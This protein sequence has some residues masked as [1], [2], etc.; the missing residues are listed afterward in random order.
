MLL[1]LSFC[2]SVNMRQ[3]SLL[4]N[5]NSS[6][7]I[8]VVGGGQLAQMLCEAAERRNIDVAIQTASN[9]DPAVKTANKLIL[10]EP[11]NIKGTRELAEGCTCVTFENEWVN[12]EEL[13]ILEKE[14]VHFLPH[15]DSLTPL[16]DKI[17]QR[18][19]LGE[20]N[21]PSTDWILLSSNE[22]SESK[23]PLDWSFPLM[24]K[25]SKGGY[26][27][28]GTKV[29]RNSND[30]CELLKTVNR[31]NWFLEK[32]VE[33]EKEYSLV[34]TRDLQGHIRAY[35]LAETNQLNQV[36][37]WVIVPA[38]ASHPVKNMA[39]NIAASLLT[40]LNYFGV[41]AI[42]FFYGNSGL[43]VNEIAPRT[44]NS[45]HFSIEA[46]KSSQFD[47]QICIAA[48]LPL[49]STDLVTPGALM[50]N[51]LGLS[52]E[53]SVSLDDR[54]NAI[55]AVKGAKLH[56][57]GKD[58]EKPGRKLGHVTFLLSGKDVISRRDEALSLLKKIRTIWPMNS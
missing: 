38:G 13:K 15:I 10:S 24:A 3:A 57:Y 52:S 16:V 37:D 50:I 58:E 30:L 22:I 48:G 56:W 20:L 11:Q 25:A 41:I 27:G 5:D 44:H 33:Y 32:W 34:A 12:I 9:S 29:I 6:K 28:K 4:R 45:A 23:L 53:Q 36:C 40:K 47:Q 46:C 7:R 43:L 1:A 26:D 21:I 18:N 54:L 51:L 42:E 17:A 14:G 35:D 2:E 55:N 31:Q 8:G 39:Y 49:T 19:L